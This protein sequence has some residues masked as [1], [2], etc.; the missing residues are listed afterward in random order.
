MNVKMRVS[1]AG[2]LKIK[3]RLRPDETELDHET[4]GFIF[5]KRVTIEANSDRLGKY[6]KSL[7]YYGSDIE[8]LEPAELRN[9]MRKHLEDAHELY[10]C[11]SSPSI[12]PIIRDDSFARDDEY[13]ALISGHQE[14]SSD[15]FVKNLLAARLDLAE[16][17][18]YTYQGALWAF[19]DADLFWKDALCTNGTVK[20]VSG[21]E[22]FG[23]FEIL[24][25]EGEIAHYADE[26]FYLA[27]YD[28]VKLEG[29]LH[30]VEKIRS[31]IL[32]L[33]SIYSL[34]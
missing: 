34:E 6:S 1:A 5:N 14:R 30:I 3:H 10:E 28:E 27:R 16:A 17:P 23:Y 25:Y 32:E 4:G 26:Y 9:M 29:P 13:D 2:A 24:H 33:K 31:R 22:K 21:Y 20:R 7:L 8:I 12:E 15:A 18:A 11:D 19:P